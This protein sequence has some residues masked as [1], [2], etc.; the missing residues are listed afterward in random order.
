MKMLCMN[1]SFIGT[2]NQ[3]IDVSQLC[4][5]IDNSARR[6]AKQALFHDDDA[7]DNNF[8][9]DAL[10]ALQRFS[11]H[12]E[13]DSCHKQVARDTCFNRKDVNVNFYFL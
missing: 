7:R 13:C 6:L 11:E 10:E 12:A 8:S 9:D 2:K 1:A 3:K 5:R 4:N